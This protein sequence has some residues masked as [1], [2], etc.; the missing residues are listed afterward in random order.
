[1]HKGSSQ[2][3]LTL[4]TEVPQAASYTPPAGL[5]GSVPGHRHLHITIPLAKMAQLHMGACNVSAFVRPQSPFPP[6]AA[7]TLPY[8]PKLLPVLP[9]TCTNQYARAVQATLEMVSQIEQRN[10]EMAE[11]ERSLLD[12]HQIFLDM[13]VLVAGQSEMLDKIEGWVRPWSQPVVLCVSLVSRRRHL[14]LG[15][16]SGAGQYRSG[17]CPWKHGT[18]P[19]AS[20]A[21]AR[22]ACLPQVKHAFACSQYLAASD[23][24]QVVCVQHSAHPSLKIK[25]PSRKMGTCLIKPDPEPLF[26]IL[27]LIR[28]L[29][30]QVV[31]T[32]EQMRCALVDLQKAKVSRRAAQQKRAITFT[33]GLA[34]VGVGAGI[35]ATGGGA[36]VGVPIALVG[37]AVAGVGAVM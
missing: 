26:K 32:Q 35:S 21:P 14:G 4:H 7:P 3:Q 16:G 34:L 12:L 24:R 5:H 6:G 22:L 27:S 20:G 30:V 19:T 1:M 36:V 2:R 25:T 13:S 28:K 11:L 9:T 18:C 31:N 17:P 15:G 8:N 29:P 33:A 10:T 23:P 37:A